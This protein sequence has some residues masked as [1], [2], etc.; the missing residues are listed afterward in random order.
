[1]DVRMYDEENPDFKQYRTI[2][3]HV[4]SYGSR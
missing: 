3:D 2:R 4:R 1:V